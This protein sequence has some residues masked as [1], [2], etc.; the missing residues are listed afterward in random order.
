M[1]YKDAFGTEDWQRVRSSPW[2]VAIAIVAADRSG[3]AATGR[4]LEALRRAVAETDAH[5]SPN[6]LIRAV[7]DDVTADRTAGEADPVGMLKGADSLVD[8]ALEHCR[9]VVAILDGV[10]EPTEAADYCAWL[11]GLAEQVAAASKE[12]G[13]LG[14]GGT[15]VSAAE[16]ATL[17]ALAV[18]LGVER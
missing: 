7:A 3:I 8:A 16:Q 11:L 6:D 9:S 18:A 4:E 12:G 10:A 1:T 13:F 14:I 5:G 15:Q 17:D 2:V